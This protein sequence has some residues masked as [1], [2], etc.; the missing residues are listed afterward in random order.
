MR[1]IEVSCVSYVLVRCTAK[2]NRVEREKPFVFVSFSFFRK[3]D[4]Y[5]KVLKVWKTES[6]I[7]SKEHRWLKLK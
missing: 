7:N 4:A 5:M 3:D 1:L 6:F 2:Q